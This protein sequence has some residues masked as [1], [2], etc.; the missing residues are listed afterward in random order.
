ME[1]IYNIRVRD[2]PFNP[3]RNCFAVLSVLG[4]IAKLQNESGLIYF[5]PV[6]D[7]EAIKKEEVAP[8]KK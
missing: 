6:K 8:M 3:V 7:L 5:Y 1:N 4:G 2:W